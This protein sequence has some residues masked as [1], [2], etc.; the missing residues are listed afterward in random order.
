MNLTFR[1]VA[2]CVS[3]IAAAVV[4]YAQN[5]PWQVVGGTVGVSLHKQRLSQMGL[6]VVNLV[7]T[8]FGDY[9]MA[10]SVGFRISKESSLQVSLFNQVF[11]TYLGGRIVLDGGFYLESKN[12]AVSMYDASIQAGGV[13]PYS[14]L[15][16]REG[17]LNGSVEPMFYLK[18]SNAALQPRL[19]N[20]IIG[21]AD[22]RLTEQ[23]ARALGRTD[24]ADAIVGEFSIFAKIRPLGAAD[25]SDPAPGDYEYDVPP[26]V[27]LIFMSS[28]SDTGRDPS[29]AYP[30]GQ[31]GLACSTTS[32]NHGTVPIDWFSPMN[33]RHP[34][35]VQNMF[36][37]RN[38][39]LEQIGAGYLKHGFFATNTPNSQ[40]GS[41]SGSGGSQLFPGL[42]D[43]YGVSNNSATNYLGP[44]FEVNPYTGRW[45]ALNSLFD[46]GVEGGTGGDGIRS[47]NGTG[48]P[49]HFRKL[50]IRDQDLIVP[51]GETW[52]FWYE[53]FYI[54]SPHGPAMN[55]LETNRDNN[56]GVRR[57]SAA[58]SSGSNRWQFSDQTALDN[59]AMIMKLPETGVLG[60]TC[61]A[62]VVNERQ[63][64]DVYVAMN[65]V[66]EGGGIYRYEF[67]VYNYF[68]DRQIREVKIP[69]IEGLNVTNIGFRDIDQNASND[70]TGTYANGEIT[71]ST[72]TF[73]QNPNA[74]SLKY[75]VLYNFSF[76]AN[77]A[78]VPNV[79]TLG[80]FKNPPVGSTLTALTGNTVA[81]PDGNFYATS[82]QIVNGFLASGGTS[83]LSKS[84]DQ[85]VVIAQSKKSDSVFKAGLVTDSTSPVANGSRLDVL[86]EAAADSAGR[87]VDVELYNWV[88][89]SYVRIDRRA[90]GT[91]D[92][93]YTVSLSEVDISSYIQPGTRLVRTRVRMSQGGGNAS[94]MGSLQ[95]DRLSCKVAL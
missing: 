56:I 55:E 11:D 85:R 35:I 44:R 20:L 5:P 24:L 88:T 90:V 68:S 78:P 38:N 53:S 70:W 77:R 69:I 27:R 82:M 14:N 60:S 41:G 30:N 65:V 13:Q 59:K 40:C 18:Y 39:R 19:G 21:Y 50:V 89:N 10:N 33:E 76:R 8:D 26:D 81:P 52:Q 54:L 29:A 61:V 84:D 28:L 34:V 4:S 86:V 42:I 95:L 12:G 15:E 75:G 36:R 16:I 71:W 47:Y 1:R 92:T 7:P 37:I 72:Q 64:G 51:T 25:Q 79:A 6:K 94:S 32:C 73:A 45:I 87:L 62:N 58:W 63:E 17:G 2:A 74:N 67:M 80:L 66:N 93:A 83:N 3:L 91:T 43:T 49:P 22:L 57:V 46:T 48:L 9:G 31:S 23:G